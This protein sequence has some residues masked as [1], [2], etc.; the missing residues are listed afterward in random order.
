[1]VSYVLAASIVAFAFAF[2]FFAVARSDRVPKTALGRVVSASAPRLSSRL[3]AVRKQLLAEPEPPQ[4][5]RR[6]KLRASPELTPEPEAHE[7][8]ARSSPRAA[9][10]K[11]EP[12]RS[13]LRMNGEII[14]P[15]ADP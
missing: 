12:R 3:S 8:R 9:A 6:A 10:P 14:D 5:D 11:A 2:G 13:R 15:W 7:T 1:M 4:R